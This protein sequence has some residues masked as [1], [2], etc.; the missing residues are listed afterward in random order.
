[1]PQFRVVKPN[2]GHRGTQRGRESHGGLGAQLC[3]KLCT[4]PLPRQTSPAAA[5]VSRLTKFLLWFAT[6]KRVYILTRDPPQVNPVP[7]VSAIARSP[8]GKYRRSRGPLPPFSRSIALD[9]LPRYGPLVRRRSP[10]LPITSGQTQRLDSHRPERD[11]PLERGLKDWLPSSRQTGE[12]EA[13]KS[14]AIW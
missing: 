8:S 11:P 12:Q 7:A 6:T 9:G 3:T 13:P 5:I 2:P 10:F 14:V 1:V 4:L